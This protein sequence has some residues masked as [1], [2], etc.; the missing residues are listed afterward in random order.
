VPAT[1]SGETLTALAP[2]PEANTWYVSV[3]DKRG[4]MVSTLVEI[5]P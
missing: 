2:P 3:T 4:A 5:L 1:V